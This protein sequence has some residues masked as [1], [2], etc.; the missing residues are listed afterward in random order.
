MQ[1]NTFKF[2]EIPPYMMHDIFHEY[3]LKMCV[4][5]PQAQ[6]H[7]LALIEPIQEPKSK[8]RDSSKKIY[9]NL[10]ENTKK[11][12]EFVQGTTS[13]AIIST[14]RSPCST[15]RPCS[16]DEPYTEVAFTRGLNAAGPVKRCIVIKLYIYARM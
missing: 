13:L 1:H 14:A 8:I 16:T 9:Q 11:I 2:I 10:E 4:H 12:K 5:T 3:V 6:S 7:S 15:G